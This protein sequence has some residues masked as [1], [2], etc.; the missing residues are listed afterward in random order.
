M[1]V[2]RWSILSQSNV[3]VVYQRFFSSKLY[4]FI[5]LYFFLFSFLYFSLINLIYFFCYFSFLFFPERKNGAWALKWN[6]LRLNKNFIMGRKAWTR[7]VFKILVFFFIFVD[8]LIRVFSFI[9]FTLFVT[10]R[11]LYVCL[12]LFTYCLLENRNNLS[13]LYYYCK[14]QVNTLTQI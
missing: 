1:F 12:S 2:R 9:Y 5:L 6:K 7:L 14:E 11:K 13:Y 4:L 8:I 10:R 3:I